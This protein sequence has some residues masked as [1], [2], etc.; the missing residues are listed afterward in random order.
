M[1]LKKI[2]P[3]IFVIFLFLHISSIKTLHSQDQ[4]VIPKFID[5]LLPQNDEISGW[6]KHESAKIYK[7]DYLFEYIN[8]G[9]EIYLEYGFKQV[10][11]QEYVCNEQSIIVD[12]YEMDDPRAAFGIYSIQYDYNK[13]EMNVGSGGTKYDFFIAFWQ[14]QYY[15]VV[16]GYSIKPETKMALEK[17]AQNI[18]NEIGESSQPPR[19]SLHLP[20]QFLI[21]RSEAFVKG[22][23]GL[24]SRIFLGHKNVL[25]LD[26][27]GVIGA[28]AVYEKDEQRAQLLVVQYSNIKLAEQKMR[29]IKNILSEKYNKVKNINNSLFK[30]S[31]GRF[32]SIKTTNNSLYIVFRSSSL[33]MINI[34]LEQT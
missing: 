28:F 9:A 7:K 27:D 5:Q 31:K 16:S 26:G 11:V 4:S 20:L 32:Y 18:S 2:H 25:E 15:V 12:I 22:I 6:V 30:D 23:L 13:P 17:F 8:G 19:I 14:N 1:K 33:E 34:I 24:N 10:I 3:A 29:I 21:P